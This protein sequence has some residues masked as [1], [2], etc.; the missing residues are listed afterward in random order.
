MQ[1]AHTGFT[2]SHA[3][4]CHRTLLP[5]IPSQYQ[6]LYPEV[7]LL[8]I[9]H[10]R[11]H[12][13]AINANIALAIGS[14]LIIGYPPPAGETSIVHHFFVDVK[15]RSAGDAVRRMRILTPWRTIFGGGRLVELA[16]GQI[17][18]QLRPHAIVKMLAYLDH[19]YTEALPEFVDRTFPGINQRRELAANL[20]LDTLFKRHDP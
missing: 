3:F 18:K 16:Q 17:C 20:P 6:A 15:R 8:A 2:P 7:Q 9:F 13:N 10:R 4:F 19:S 12:S 1:Y 5:T 11:E 14:S